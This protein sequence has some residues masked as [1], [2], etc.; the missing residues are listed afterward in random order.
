MCRRRAYA[1]ANQAGMEARSW[2]QGGSE[3]AGHCSRET[4]KHLTAAA[5]MGMHLSSGVCD[6]TVA[7]REKGTLL[8][9]GGGLQQRADCTHKWCCQQ[10]MKY[11]TRGGLLLC[12]AQSWPVSASLGFV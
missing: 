5:G 12:A 10:S 9:Q 2:M 8:E 4:P 1:V 3:D 7:V 6:E 11:W